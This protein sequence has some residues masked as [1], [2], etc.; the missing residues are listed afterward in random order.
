MDPHERL[1]AEHRQ[2]QHRGRRFVELVL[3]ARGRTDLDLSDHDVDARTP[4]IER[5]FNP[6]V[7]P[8]QSVGSSRRTQSIGTRCRRAPSGPGPSW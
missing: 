5:G 7:S 8:G 2:D 6:S 3:M 1:V 4:G